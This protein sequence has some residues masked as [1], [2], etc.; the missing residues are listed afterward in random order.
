MAPN[1]SGPA[2]ILKPTRL[3]FFE[4]I[5]MYQVVDTFFDYCQ[6]ESLKNLLP[7]CSLI[8]SEVFICA[9]L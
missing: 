4:R 2:V 1:V 7:K 5:G 6:T 3:S 9:M 8:M